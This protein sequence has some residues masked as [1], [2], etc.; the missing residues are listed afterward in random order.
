MNSVKVVVAYRNRGWQRAFRFLKTLEA[1]SRKPDRVVLVD[2]GEETPQLRDWRGDFVY[3][4][5]WLPQGMP[6]SRSLA[7][8]QG[9]CLTPPCDSVL[10]TDIDVLFAPNFI[11]CGLEKLQDFPN[12]CLKCLSLDLP[13]GAIS[14]QTDVVR[15]F[16]KIA[17]LGVPTHS[18]NIGRCQWIGESIF[19][20]LRG[21]D[22]S[23]FLWGNEDTDFH[24]RI[25]WL[26]AYVICLEEDTQLLHEWHPAS[27]QSALNEQEKKLFESCLLHN[28]GLIEQRLRAFEEGHFDPQTVNPQ[29]W[30]RNFSA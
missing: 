4:Y 15:E 9:V 8:N 3:D 20:Q 11:Q 28:R 30:G 1:Q 22:E 25:L 23:M 26:G 10:L 24:R 21:L 13:E 16:A 17:K 7:L 6:W 2:F 27:N 12:A 5:L 19:H 29:G 18:R 14:E